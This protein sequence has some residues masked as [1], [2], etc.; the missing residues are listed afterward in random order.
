MSDTNTDNFIIIGILVF[1]FYKYF[2]FSKTLIKDNFAN[3]PDNNVDTLINPEFDYES[4]ERLTDT[5]PYYN[6]N[7][8]PNSFIDS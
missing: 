5:N 3:L 8:L 2:G 4:H 6:P 7:H 1:I